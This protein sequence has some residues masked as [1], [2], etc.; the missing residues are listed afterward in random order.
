MRNCWQLSELGNTSACG[1]HPLSRGWGLRAE[2]T[3][4]SIMLPIWKS[5][6][7]DS[8]YSPRWFIGIKIDFYYIT[9]N[10]QCT[11][12][13][14]WQHTLYTD[15]ARWFQTSPSVVLLLILILLH[16]S[17]ILTTTFISKGKLNTGFWNGNLVWAIM[18]NNFISGIR[19]SVDARKILIIK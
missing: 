12:H 10:W 11:L 18:R 9:W 8:F 15:S 16:N 6:R 5:S 14:D 2:S 17:W 13:V 7:K 19:W 3:R 4:N 1:E